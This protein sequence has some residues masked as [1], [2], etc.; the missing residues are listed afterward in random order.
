MVSDS[1]SSN[2][3]HFYPEVGAG[4]FSR[5]DGTVS[6]Y[7]RVN[8]LLDPS[9]TVLDLG[10][11][12]GA[13][14]VSDPDSYRTKLATIKGKVAKVIGIDVDDAVLSNP[15]LDEAHVIRIGEPYPFADNSFDLILSDWVLEHVAN[16]E[17]FAAEIGRVLKPGGWFC[18]R[19]PNRWGMVGLATNLVPN[20]AHSDLL[21]KL[22]PG[23]T[24]RD[25]FPTTYKLNTKGRLVR[26]FPP[27]RWNNYSYIT[28]PEPPYVQRSAL[29]MRV[30]QFAWRFAPP[31]MGTVFNVFL[32][33]KDGAKA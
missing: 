20:K 15:C 19:T 28:N 18:A 24:E 25:V 10:A 7:T 11:G 1:V 30:V 3:S 26:A 33:Q 22:Q 17:E 12:R 29:A 5:V 32:Q 6:F 9:F 2:L 14:L 13:Q 4:G 21:A 8:A 31:Q 27:D 23:R 16:P